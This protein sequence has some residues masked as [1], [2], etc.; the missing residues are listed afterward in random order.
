MLISS[1]LFRCYSA[2]TLFCKRSNLIFNSLFL[3]ISTLLKTSEG[4]KEPFT[5]MEVLSLLGINNIV[6]KVWF[7]ET[8]QIIYPVFDN[9]TKEQEINNRSAILY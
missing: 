8:N 9:F 2:S 6:T 3:K 5:P 1:Y 7:P 4:I